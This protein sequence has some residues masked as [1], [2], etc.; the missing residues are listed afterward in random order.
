MKTARLIM[1]LTSFLFIIG[2]GSSDP[3]D[4]KATDASTCDPS[5]AMMTTGSQAIIGTRTITKITNSSGQ[6][7]QETAASG[8]TSTS[9]VCEVPAGTY[10]VGGSFNGSFNGIIGM[11]PLTQA[12]LI[13][14]PSTGQCSE[15]L[16]ITVDTNKIEEMATVTSLIEDPASPYVLYITAIWPAS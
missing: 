5:I 10:T 9:S 7:V 16:T 15:A 8:C 14:G 2:C 1:I 11:G 3:A 13:D 12:G 4:S 6:S